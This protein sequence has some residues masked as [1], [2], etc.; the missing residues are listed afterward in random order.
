M[1]IVFS[2]PQGTND[3]MAAQQTVQLDTLHPFPIGTRFG[4][5]VVVG[6]GRG[7]H[8]LTALCKCDCGSKVEIPQM[9]FAYYAYNS[10]EIRLGRL[11]ETK[12]IPRWSKDELYSRWRSMKN[13][14]RNEKH[15]AYRRYGGRGIKVCDEWARSFHEFK[16]WAISHG[17][18]KDLEIDRIDNDGNYEPSN[19]RF[20]TRSE[21]M[22][23][24]GKWI[25]PNAKSR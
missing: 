24:R 10:C 25:K 3:P 1:T 17:Y 22:R 4:H 20:V 12:G 8:G 14:C 23:N 19:C 15:R 13:R 18:R 7:L 6:H 2:R 9:L 21:N 11:E 5:L 16:L